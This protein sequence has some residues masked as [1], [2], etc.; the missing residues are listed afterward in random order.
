MTR[1]DRCWLNGRR[2]YLLKQEQAA[3]AW[4]A[5]AEGLAAL[6]DKDVPR[7]DDLMAAIRRATVRGKHLKRESTIV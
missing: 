2:A 4:Q 5:L 6:G 1:R 7:F 3:H